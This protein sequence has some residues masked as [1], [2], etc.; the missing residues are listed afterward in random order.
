MWQDK[1]ESGTGWPSFTRPYLP[2]H[3]LEERL[4]RP[5]FETELVDPRSG[6]HLGYV[7]DDGPGG[8]KRYTVNSATLDFVH[9]VN[10]RRKH[11]RFPTLWLDKAPAARNVLGSL[12]Q[13][14]QGKRYNS[15]GSLE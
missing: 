5:P 11:G 6:A 1:C 2:G 10:F 13:R 14:N 7:Y 4:P 9:G 15:R 12:R 3:V 8:G